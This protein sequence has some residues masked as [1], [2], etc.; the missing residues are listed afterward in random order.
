MINEYF[1]QPGSNPRNDAAHKQEQTQPKNKKQRHI[2]NN[3][4]TAPQAMAKS[5]FANTHA[6]MAAKHIMHCNSTTIKMHRLREDIRAKTAR[7]YVILCFLELSHKGEYG[8]KSLLLVR[9]HWLSELH[10]YL[11]SDTQ[12][13]HHANKLIT[14]IGCHTDQPTNHIKAKREHIPSQG[15]SYSGTPKLG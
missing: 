13:N 14:H 4:F 3:M 12:V 8:M 11:L 10:E 15:F 5:Q 6:C 9:Q 1:H 7:T 2:I